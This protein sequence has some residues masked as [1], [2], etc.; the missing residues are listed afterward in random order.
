VSSAT[1]APGR[2]GAPIAV[3][4]ISLL[5]AGWVITLA[6]TAVVVLLLPPPPRPTFRLSDIVGAL[7]GGRLVTHEGRRL[8]ESQGES[9]GVRVIY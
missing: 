8:G 9:K 6:V 3:Q 2:T 5:A 4:M 1:P 7:Q